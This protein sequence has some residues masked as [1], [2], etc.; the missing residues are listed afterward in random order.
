MH[1]RLFTT[2]LEPGKE[3]NM[4]RALKRALLLT[5]FI[6][7][8]LALT[9][10]GTSAASADGYADDAAAIADGKVARVGGTATSNDGATYYATLNDA[11]THVSAENNVVWL[12]TDWTQTGILPKGNATP[13]NYTLTS[14]DPETVTLY[15]NTGYLIDLGGGAT[16]V[17]TL[18]N[19]NIVAQGSLGYFNGVHVIIEEGFKISGPGNSSYGLLYATGAAH[20]EIKGG[21][22]ECTGGANKIIV[23]EGNANVDISGGTLIHQGTGFILY[24]NSANADVDVTGT[25]VLRH[26]G[27][28]TG[29]I[30]YRKGGNI[31]ASGADV[32]LIAKGDN[33]ISYGGYDNSGNVI[34]ENAFISTERADKAICYYEAQYMSLIN[35]Q[36][37]SP[38]DAIAMIGYKTAGDVNSAIPMLPVTL[39]K[40]EAVYS[41]FTGAMSVAGNGGTIYVY[42]DFAGTYEISTGARTFT[43]EG[44]QKADGTYPT[45]THVTNHALWNVQANA[46]V[47]LKNLNFYSH[48]YFAYVSGT[49]NYENCNL[50]INGGYNH[51]FV[52][53]SDSCVINFNSGNI[54]MED[55]KGVKNNLVRHDKGTIYL[56]GTDFLFEMGGIVNDAFRVVGKM[57]MND[58][59]ILN[60]SANG[61]VYAPSG[62]VEING[63]VME[64]AYPAAPIGT[65]LIYMSGSAAVMDMNGGELYARNGVAAAVYGE[66]EATV[67]VYGGW[68]ENNGES[69]LLV[70]S[71]STLNIYGGTIILQ[72]SHKSLG[73]NPVYA[74]L[75]CSRDN[76]VSSVSI[77]GGLFI[78]N[79]DAAPI[80]AAGYSRAVILKN[81]A[82]SS[83]KIVGGTFMAT[84]FQDFYFKSE[85]SA[86]GT[87]QIPV[88]DIP[89]VKKDNLK[90]TFGDRTYYYMT[91]SSGVAVAPEITA[92]VQLLLTEDGNGIMFTS[93][94]SAALYAALVVWCD[95]NA[96]EGSTLEFGTMIASALNVQQAG[97][98]T[99]KAF[100]EAGLVYLNIPA[101][102]AGME[103]DEDGNLIFR[104]AMIDIQ[105]GYYDR[106]FTAVPYA[107]IVTPDATDE[108]VIY[109]GA[110]NTNKAAAS[111]SY[112][113]ELAL[114]D[115]NA[116]LGG[117]YQF[118]S[119]F[120]NKAYNRYTAEQQTMLSEYLTHRHT[121]D[122]KGFCED[123]QTSV[124]EELANE[125]SVRIYTNYELVRYFALTLEG[126]VTYRIAQTNK[127]GVYKLYNANG[128][129]CTVTD[130]LFECEEDGTYYLVYHST[131]VGST[132]LSVEHIHECSYDGY[133]SVCETSYLVDLEN[134]TVYDLLQTQGN[135]Y[136]YRV[137]FTENVDYLILTVNATYVVYNA[138]GQ[139]CTV[140]DSLFHCTQSGEY[141][142]VATAMISAKASVKVEHIHSYN[143]KGECNVSNCDDKV[144]KQIPGIFKDKGNAVTGALLKGDTHYY[145]IELEQGKVYTVFVEPF[146]GIYTVYTSAGEAVSLDRTGSFTCAASG[147]Y[148][149]VLEV[150]VNETSSVYFSYRHDCD[151]NHKGVCAICGEDVS[152]AFRQG[153]TFEIDNMK[154]GETKY[155]EVRGPYSAA[156]YTLTLPENLAS[157]TL[158]KADGTEIVISDG[159]FVLSENYD[160]SLYLKMTTDTL[161]AYGDAKIAHVHTYNHKGYCEISGCTNNVRVNLTVGVSKPAEAE[162]NY[163]RIFLDES[164]EY[165][166]LLN[167]FEGTWALYD[168]EGAVL[169]TSGNYTATAEGYYYLVVTVTTPAAEGEEA[170]VVVN[171][172]VEPEPEPEPEPVG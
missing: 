60:Q 71:N 165:T 63:G 67:N 49:L 56:N 83:V 172:V 80:S 6:V 32:K 10:I 111:M 31:D 75:R 82:S 64:T 21:T 142:I 143:F 11:I 26:E 50:V 167:G 137:E 123:C 53:A 135:N 171:E 70:N 45:I 59:H 144:T 122:Y 35:V 15:S 41:S 43:V 149:L 91:F 151:Y 110:F 163:Y 124:L 118:R 9:I 161:A 138:A 126:D 130:G 52:T 28:G 166:V 18:K 77:Y 155:F 23:A 24:T 170:T 51:G 79:N 106:V 85:G 101:T 46:N 47:T 133:C 22:F 129:L 102:S 55:A 136:Y 95:D 88:A 16:I 119:L 121:P 66:S 89:V 104:A 109:Y 162:K 112:L 65:Y 39:S 141:Y 4:N 139:L 34:I 157:V 58:G 62:K 19:I 54:V 168:E 3:V 38:E 150:Q 114:Y 116:V 131:R 44:I 7:C 147:T 48:G 113:A 158:Y 108:D 36:V 94:L 132:D 90:T 146:A 5:L 61:I 84:E 152:Q 156:T 164:V 134:D 20:V 159:T 160:G 69:V 33:Y 78:N 29:Y 25:A 115:N 74:V 27:T 97:A 103:F 153:E 87:V 13:V 93:K 17:P 154:A 105:E 86:S 68:I 127:V 2:G 92:D 81:S 40:T 169:A 37:E 99:M 42:A 8:V 98:M 76:G 120:V 1:L 14:T 125:S 140:R 145:S 72:A 128:E 57:V 117:E 73:G 12:V 96:P 30:F 100:E 148:Y 107:K